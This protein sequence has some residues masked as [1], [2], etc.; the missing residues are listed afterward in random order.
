MLHALGLEGSLPHLPIHYAR[1]GSRVVLVQELYRKM[2]QGP[3]EEMAEDEDEEALQN[4]LATASRS[5]MLAR[6]GLRPWLVNG[7]VGLTPEHPATAS[8]P[9][10]ED[11]DG[12]IV[13]LHAW[14]LLLAHLIGLPPASIGS[15]HLAQGLG[16]VFE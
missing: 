10:V 12:G 13:R 6:V 7:L 8:H 5:D 15:R 1:V 9:A 4:S 16:D 2:M 14:A 11:E 3:E